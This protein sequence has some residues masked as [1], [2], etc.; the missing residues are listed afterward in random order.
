MFA[1]PRVM[2]VIRNC[3]A[4]SFEVAVWNDIYLI[5]PRDRSYNG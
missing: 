1:L 2:E 5:A 3:M 4:C